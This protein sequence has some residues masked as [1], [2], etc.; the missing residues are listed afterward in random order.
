MNDGSVGVVDQQLVLS[1]S[2][3]SMGPPLDRPICI[4]GKHEGPP[5][6]LV[7]T[8]GDS[9]EAGHLQLQLEEPQLGVHLP[10]M[11]TP[12]QSHGEDQDRQGAGNGHHTQ[13]AI[14]DLVSNTQGN[15]QQ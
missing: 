11:V 12:Q 10:T 8:Q 15:G 1:T 3:L 13:M 7:A 2:R 14:H 4:S 5:I 6:H 9:L